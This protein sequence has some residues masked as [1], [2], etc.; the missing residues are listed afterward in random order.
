MIR[1]AEIHSNINVNSHTVSSVPCITM[2][3]VMLNVIEMM[4]AEPFASQR[5]NPY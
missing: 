5:E 1:I 3:L 4:V 2:N